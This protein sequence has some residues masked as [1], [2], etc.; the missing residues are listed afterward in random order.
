M[1]TAIGIAAHVLIFAAAI[2]I[3]YLGLG[4]GLAFHPGLAVLIWIGA[5][6]MVVG[7]IVWMV[8]RLLRRIWRSG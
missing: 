2:I 3:F 8:R 1:R 7:N 4:V 5:A 6:I